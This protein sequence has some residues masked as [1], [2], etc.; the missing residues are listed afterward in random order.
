MFKDVRNTSGVGRI[1]LEAD[2]EDIVG[3]VSCYV[4]IVGARLVVLEV[5][6]RQLQ[7]GDMF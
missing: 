4:Q 2:A 5:Q 1:C 7:L 3:V 6:R